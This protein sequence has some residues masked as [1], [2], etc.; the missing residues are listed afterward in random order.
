MILKVQLKD[1]NI[2]KSRLSL[3]IN[4]KFQDIC[5]IKIDEIEFVVP[6]IISDKQ[7][8]IIDERKWE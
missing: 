8:G 7:Q 3:D 4:S 2:D 6:Y 1:S 5:R